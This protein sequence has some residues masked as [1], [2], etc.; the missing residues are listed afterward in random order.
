MRVGARATALLS[1]AERGLRRPAPG[2]LGAVGIVDDRV[3]AAD[4][5]VRELARQSSTQVNGAAPRL[6]EEKL[7]AIRLEVA[8]ESPGY[9]VEGASHARHNI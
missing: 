5:A 3:D 4:R 6:A 8:A 7:E 9:H 1:V 2:S